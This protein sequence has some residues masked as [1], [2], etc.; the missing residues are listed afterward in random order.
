MVNNSHKEK[1][2]E[3]NTNVNIKVEN[4]RGRIFKITRGSWEMH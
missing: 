1:T 3:S 4:D 2:S